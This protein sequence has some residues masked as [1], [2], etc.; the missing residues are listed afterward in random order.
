MTEEKRQHLEF[1]QNNISRMN[2]SSF[3]IKG[4]AVTIVTAV[5]A[6][7][8]AVPVR[9]D[10]C[11]TV[12]LFVGVIPTL[13][14]WILDSYYLQQEKKF[15]GIYEDVISGKKVGEYKMP[16]DKYKRGKYSLYRCM[17]TVSEWTIYFV[18]I[19]G[20]SALGFVFM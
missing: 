4:M 8:V 2:Q 17:W 16:L 1:I 20:L 15:R 7:Y 12:F 3:Q 14:F 18:I 19:I 9:E 10:M 11:S 6:A 5:I 13:I